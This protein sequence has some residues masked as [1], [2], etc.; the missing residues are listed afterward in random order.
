MVDNESIH[1]GNVLVQSTHPGPQPR[2]HTRNVNVSEPHTRN[3][4][5]SEPH[6]LSVTVSEPH[7]GH[8]TAPAQA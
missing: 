2:L 5:V 6:N 7:R 8:Q 1:S 4:N 3:V